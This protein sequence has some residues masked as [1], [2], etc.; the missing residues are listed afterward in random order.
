M[1]YICVYA[2]YRLYTPAGISTL[3]RMGDLRFYHRA[4]LVFLLSGFLSA[5]HAWGQHNIAKA[6]LLS[7]FILTPNVSYER[8]ISRNFSGQLGFFYTWAQLPFLYTFEGYGITAE[9]RYY[10]SKDPAPQGLYLAPWGRYQNLDVRDD[11]DIYGN[12][13]GF[14][15]GLLFG[16]QW[17]FRE[18]LT[19]DLFIGPQYLSGKVKT[20]PRSAQ[21][22]VAGNGRGFW[23]RAGLNLG[24]AF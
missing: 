9:F 22:V 8:V 3:L 10:F 1:D 20:D 6:N 7:P 21:P 16:R 2:L 11:P 12:I 24:I 5:T 17:L 18:R 13:S 23:F 15:G 14:S 4:W 19:F